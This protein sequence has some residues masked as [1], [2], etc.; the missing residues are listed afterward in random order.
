MRGIW[1][2]LKNLLGSGFARDRMAARAI[3]TVSAF[4]LIGSYIYFAIAYFFLGQSQFVVNTLVGIFE[5]LFLTLFLGGLIFGIILL[6]REKITS[7]EK[8][9]WQLVDYLWVGVGALGFIMFVLAYGASPDSIFYDERFRVLMPAIGTGPNLY[10]L[11]LWHSLFAILTSFM[12]LSEAFNRIGWDKKKFGVIFINIY[13]ALVFAFMLTKLTSMRAIEESAISLLYSWD[14]DYSNVFAVDEQTGEA[15][16]YCP[17]PDTVAQNI[18]RVNAENAARI[19]AGEP[20]LRTAP[21]YPLPPGVRDDI[22]I[23]GITTADITAVKGAWPLDWGIYAQVAQRTQKSEN[24]ILVYDINF[25]DAK[26]VFGCDQNRYDCNA[27]EGFSLRRQDELLA[28]SIAATPNRIVADYPIEMT[29]EALAQEVDYEN[30]LAALNEM[31]ALRNVRNASYGISWTRLVIP[32]I[33]M[34]TRELYSAGH[35]NVFI[36]PNVTKVNRKVPLV[37]RVVN[38]DRQDKPDYDPNVDDSFYPGVALASAI[39]YYG[40][41]PVKDVEVDFLNGYVKIKNIPQRSRLVM[42][43]ELFRMEEIDIM[44]KPNAERTV[45]LPMDRFGLMNINFRG[46]LYCFHYHNILD[47]AQ[48]NKPEDVEILMKDKIALVAMYYATGVSTAKDIH[49]SP[50]GNMAGIEHQAYAI[51][52]ILNQDFA[53]EASPLVNLAILMVIGIITAFFQPRVPTWMSFVLTIIIATSFAAITAYVSFGLYSYLHVFFAVIFEQFLMLIIFILYRA[54]TEE[55]NVKYIR[56]TFSKFV[57]QDVVN[58]LLAN[59]DAIALG[60]AKKEI[61]V[62]FSDVRGFTTISEKLGPEELVKLLNEYLSEMTELIIHYRGTIDKYMGDAIMAFWGAPVQNDD[63]AY[64]ACVAALAQS[65]RLKELQ[66]G[67]RERGD[68]SID[69]GIGINT[70]MAVVG[71]MGS[72][73]RM[74][75]TIMGDTVNLGSRLEGITKT[76][77]VKICI[78]E[79]T[80]ERVKDRVYARELDL[81]RVKGKNE[82]VRIYEL[83]GLKDDTDLNRLMD[84]AAPAAARGGK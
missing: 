16:P 23:V 48:N 53:R 19:A 80:Y 51:N 83:M 9:G 31:S 29:T 30:R 12:F 81:V 54:L 82:P 41:D 64:F 73:R 33:A 63:H 20:G 15:L 34:V 67:W 22:H 84:I 35:A 37:I 70:G 28:E 24:N 3:I 13:I 10:T 6:L 78:S 74:D 49:L 76:Y 11:V 56:N 62:F 47:I 7:R 55:E 36:D 75:Y 50:Y 25:L 72:S 21:T 27:R 46:G 17:K 14:R 58:E 69:I 45:T 60:G 68:F 38:V 26:G 32:P 39:A 42:N 79:F 44:A 57:S 43:Q 71:N 18:A 61:S 66:A 77:G 59:P 2:F 40:V 1:S 52:T 5:E 8:K 65:R 4:A